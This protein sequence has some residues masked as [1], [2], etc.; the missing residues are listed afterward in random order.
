MQTLAEFVELEEIV[1]RSRFVAKAARVE[2]PDEAMAFLH[3]V[4]DAEATHNCWAYRIDAAYRFSDDGEPGGTAGRP[5]LS[6]IE[7]QGFEHVAVV[8]TRYFGGIKLG[9]GGLVRAYSGAAANCLRA[10][11]RVEVIRRIRASLAVPFPLLGDV[12]RVLASYPDL[13][14]GEQFL[15]TGVIY[16]FGV[17]E[18][19]RGA[20]EVHVR[21]ATRGQVCVTWKDSEPSD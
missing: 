15:D 2:S 20:F 8:V 14:A 18:S 17:P 19:L 21:D 9:A 3:S 4:S 13:S 1:K 10:G 12:R 11:K 6:A 5:I 7:G 16:T